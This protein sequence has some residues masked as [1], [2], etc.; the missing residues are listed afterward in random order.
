VIAAQALARIDALE[1]EVATLRL[2]LELVARAEAIIRRANWPEA[3]LYL[4]ARPQRGKNRPRRLK[5]V[6]P[7][8]GQQS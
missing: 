3:V 1:A 5:A 2:R 4:R 8:G 6:P 7:I